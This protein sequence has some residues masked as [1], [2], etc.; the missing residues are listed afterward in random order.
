MDKRILLLRTF[1]EIPED[2]LDI[3]LL[4]KVCGKFGKL[5]I[6]GSQTGNLEIRQSLLS[7]RLV[8]AQEIDGFVQFVNAKENTWRRVIIEEILSADTIIIRFTPKSFEFPELVTPHPL[9]DVDYFEYYQSGFQQIH[10]GAGLLSEVAYCNRLEVLNRCFL[11]VNEWQVKDLE[12]AISL[13][14]LG[15]GDI[16]KFNGTFPMIPQRPRFTALDF[17]LASLRDVKTALALPQRNLV[18]SNLK[19]INMVIAELSGRIM[20]I[21]N[22]NFPKQN[23][24]TRQNLG[25]LDYGVSS[26]PKKVFPDYE[27]KV[28]THTP[29]ENLLAMSGGEL[30][31]IDYDAVIRDYGLEI[32]SAVC[33]YCQSERGFLFFY[34]Y[35]HSISKTDVVRCKCQF[36]TRRSTLESGILM[37]Q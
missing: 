18:F 36:C 9:R 30:I 33:P 6:A 27:L 17:Q 34:Q 13:A 19:Y 3:A 24:Q 25:Y 37:D 23:L 8:N 32:K 29:V 12:K 31:E 28:I 26:V 1:R 5:I 4:A 14:S 7:T 20:E 10:S 15:T 2:D 21:L 22:S 16:F 11:L 35:G